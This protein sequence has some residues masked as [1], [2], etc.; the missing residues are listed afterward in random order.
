MS[1]PA[2]PKGS[3]D[4][5]TAT[6]A[7]FSHSEESGIGGAPGDAVPW[8]ICIIAFHDAMAPELVARFE[9]IIEK[10][11]YRE[12]AAFGSARL[13]PALAVRIDAL[14][15]RL[16]TS[17]TARRFLVSLDYPTGDYNRFRRTKWLEVNLKRFAQTHGCPRPFV[18]WDDCDE[19]V[20]LLQEVFGPEEVQRLRRTIAEVTD[21]FRTPFPVVRPMVGGSAVSRAKVELVEFE[22]G[23]A[24]CKV[25]KR[26]YE[27]RLARELEL[28][29]S[30][31]GSPF[32]PEILA[33]GPNW[34]VT[35]YYAGGSLR[36]RIRWYGL[37]PV[38]DA[39][40]AMSALRFLHQRGWAH[41][42]FHLEN[43]LVDGD[44]SVRIVDFEAA[45]RYLDGPSAFEESYDVIGA[46][47]EIQDEIGWVPA[48]YQA[49]WY[50][51]I[52][53]DLRTLLDGTRGEQWRKRTL[54]ALTLQPKRLWR[55]MVRKVT[56]TTRW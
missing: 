30:C 51:H 11:G 29:R 56:P 55:R 1:N 50:P 10:F 19:G 45:R 7:P 20:D 34:Y 8:E 3:T 41:H 47:E 6:A 40:L 17:A 31:A 12:L 22:G 13:P 15:D 54:Y 46:P 36:Q 5:T 26:G 25:F 53:L 48:T 24:V 27:D 52:G 39:R 4:V 38:S 23:R 35:P 18:L 42:D 21:A 32:L 2:A 9:R 16:G 44:H 28:L 37:L 33:T 49:R 43:V 14:A